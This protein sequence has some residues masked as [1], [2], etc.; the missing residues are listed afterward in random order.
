MSDRTLAL[1]I[2]NL[3][4]DDIKRIRERVREIEKGLRQRDLHNYPEW[5]E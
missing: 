4:I 5:K 3:S 2:A 1:V